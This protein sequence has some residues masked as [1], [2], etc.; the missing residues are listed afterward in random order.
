MK[1]QILRLSVGCALTMAFVGAAGHAV[2]RVSAQGIISNDGPYKLTGNSGLNYVGTSHIYDPAS[3]H[4]YTSTRGGIYQFDTNTMKVVSRAPSVR[5][6]GSMSLDASR[7]ELY[8]LALHD[9]VMNVVDVTTNKIIRTFSAPAWFNVFYDANRGELYYLRGDTK[10]MQVADRQTGRVLKTLT[11]KGRPSFLEG[12]AAHHRLLVRLADKPEIQIIDTNEREIIGSWPARQDGPSAMA[13]SSD[14]ARVFI[15]SG[16]D[17]LMLDGT[18]GKELAKFGVGGMVESIVFD[19]ATKLLVALS[20]GHMNVATVEDASMTL[21]QS[22]RTGAFVQEIFLDPKTHRIFGISRLYD[23]GVM[24]DYASQ[25][26]P[27]DGG[28]TLLTLTL[29]Q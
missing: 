8:V 10:E 12:D 4:L 29:R 27:A 26:L 13:I 6:A 9:D 3:N 28:S 2:S 17:V 23:D 21:R 7:N 16:R 15:S 22:L 24:R 19:P 18:S 14:G 25:S 11:L 1:Q 5:G 20:G